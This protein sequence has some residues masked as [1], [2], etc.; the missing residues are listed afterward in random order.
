MT[1]TKTNTN[2]GGNKNSRKPITN[3]VGSDL[4]EKNRMN[5]TVND[6]DIRPPRNELQLYAPRQYSHRLV[7][8][9]CARDKKLYPNSA[10]YTVELEYN[11]KEVLSIELVQGIIPF[12][13]YLINETN[14]AL[15]FQETTQEIFQVLIPV[16]NYTPT[17]LAAA[18]QTA[19]NN[20]GT[21]TYTVTVLNGVKKFKFSSNWFDDNCFKLIFA[22]APCSPKDNGNNNAPMYQCNSI[23]PVIGFSPID[24]SYLQGAFF[25]E[26]GS[27]TVYGSGT[28]FTTMIMAGDK[29]KFGTNDT[30]YTVMEVISDTILK[31]TANHVGAVNGCHARLN[32]FISNNIY[33]FGS[34]SYIALFLNKPFTENLN[35]IKSNNNKIQDAFCIIPKFL[36][37]VNNDVMILNRSSFPNINNI[38]FYYPTAG[39]LSKMAIRFTDKYGNLYNFNGRE[40]TLEFNIQTLNNI[41]N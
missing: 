17:E 24:F 28:K 41:G 25:I 5:Q 31:L 40:H 15:Y 16:G 21:S 36:V 12:S 27:D 39:Q 26:N 13:G 34:D 38:Y 3:P 30:E 20:I 35:K 18:M 8:D 23:G 22:G 11:Y 33:D 14:N 2:I 37:D 1:S 29:I 6:H 9:S 32:A 7:I 19:M 4:N 10:E